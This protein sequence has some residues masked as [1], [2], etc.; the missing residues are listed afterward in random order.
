V[1]FHFVEC[2]GFDSVKSILIK[3]AALHLDALDAFNPIQGF[4]EF[5]RGAGQAQTG[6]VHDIQRDA[7]SGSAHGYQVRHIAE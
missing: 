2:F 4:H 6:F 5:V 3:V 7:L 1:E